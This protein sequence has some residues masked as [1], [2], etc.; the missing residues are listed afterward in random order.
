MS[1]YGFCG[2]AKEYASEARPSMRREHNQVDTLF[3]SYANDFRS[4]FAVHDNFLNV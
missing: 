3:F 1:Y 4:R 2:G